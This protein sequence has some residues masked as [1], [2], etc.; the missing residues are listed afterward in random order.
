MYVCGTL[1]CHNMSTI[2]YQPGVCTAI[3]SRML[4]L[5]LYQIIFIALIMI[6]T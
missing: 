2:A 5:L 4:F 1:H 6:I 3:E